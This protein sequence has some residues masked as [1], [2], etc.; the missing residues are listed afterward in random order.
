MY[1][2]VE[3]ST[4]KPEFDPLNPDVPFEIALQKFQSD[5]EREAYQTLVLDQSKRKK[6]QPHN[7]RKIKKN[8]DKKRIDFMTWKIFSF[9]YA[10][11]SV[12]QSNIQL[13][14]YNF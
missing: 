2:S 10:Y 12:I 13:E 3:N 1:L 6:F 14:S 4:T 9:S 5:A 11:G 8:P 7:V